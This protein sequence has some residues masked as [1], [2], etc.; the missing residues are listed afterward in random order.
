MTTATTTRPAWVELATD[1]PAAAHDFYSKLLGW[2]IDVSDDPQYGG[3]AM[4]HLDEGEGDVAGI[5]AKMMPEAPTAWNLYI[6]TD[7]AAALCDAVEAAGGTVMAPAFDVGDMGR[8]AV[9]AD[10]TG[11]VISAWQGTSART[12]RSGDTGAY[13]WAELSSRGL[14]RAIPFYEKVFG[15]RAETNPMGEG[16]PDYTQFH[17]GDDSV[18]GAMEM[19]PGIPDEVPSYW[20]IYFNV[21]DVDAAFKRAVDLGGSEVVAPSPM[22]GGRFAIVNDPHGA[23]FGL[24]DMQAS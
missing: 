23:M 5:T 20:M 22:P 15:W 2:T 11:A 18:A 6:E 16:Q 17:A 13:G 8:M 9:F 12:F 24:L 4:A 19:Q 7:D 3:Y 21:D 1:D 10:P 14:D